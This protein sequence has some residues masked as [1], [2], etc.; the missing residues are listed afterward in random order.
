MSPLRGQLALERGRA[1]PAL[2][3]DG[4][5][6]AVEREQLAHAPHVERHH[7]AVLAAQRRHAA[8]HARAAAEGHDRHDALAQ[9]SSSARSCA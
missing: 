9:S 5:R 8:D 2:H 3:A 7:A 4:Q 6:L 1:H